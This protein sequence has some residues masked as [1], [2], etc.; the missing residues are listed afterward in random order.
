MK[1]PPEVISDARDQIL[2]EVSNKI[3]EH[4]NVFDENY[5]LST[6][7]VTILFPREDIK[8]VKTGL[9]GASCVVIMGN[10]DPQLIGRVKPN[11]KAAEFLL[12]KYDDDYKI[13]KGKIPALSKEE[14][15]KLYQKY[16]EINQNNT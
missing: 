9:I 3:P 4:E 10:K 14:T 8:W 15:N 5:T 2:R 12:K 16:K 1:I 7:G 11:S 6:E 13:A